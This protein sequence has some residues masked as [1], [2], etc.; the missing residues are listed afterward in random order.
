MG[1]GGT[2]SGGE[3]N[4]QWRFPVPQ[5]SHQRDAACEFLCFPLLQ[6]RKRIQNAVHHAVGEFHQQ[7]ASVVEPI[8]TCQYH[9]ERMARQLPPEC[10]EQCHGMKIVQVVHQDSHQTGTAGI[11]H[12]RR[13]IRPISENFDRRLHFTAKFGTD[14]TL[15]AQSMR[16][17]RFGNPQIV[18]HIR[19]GYMT[20]HMISFI[21]NSQTGLRCLF[22]YY[23]KPVC[24]SQ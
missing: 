17:R 5:V 18:R 23:T 8:G 21:L 1:N 10:L 15:P 2:N 16:N 9:P 24:K 12:P 19:Y 11:H 22:I 3:I 20:A 7:G 13:K 14:L 4:L 6:N